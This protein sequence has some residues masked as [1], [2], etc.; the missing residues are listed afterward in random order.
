MP[1]LL[2]DYAFDG[3]TLG[4]APDIDGL[5]GAFGKLC[6]GRGYESGFRSTPANAIKDTDMLGLSLV[7]IDTDPLRVWLQWNRGFNIFDAPMM[8]NTYFGNT[9]PQDQSGRYRLVGRRRHEHASRKSAQGISICSRTGGLSVTHPNQNVSSQFGFQGLM[10]GGILPAGG[11]DQQDRHR[12]RAWVCAMTCR[13]RPSWASSSTTVPR[14]GSRSRRPPT[15]C[16]P[17]RSGVRGNVYE[18]YVIQELDEQFRSRRN[19]QGLLPPRLSVLRLPV[20][21]QQQLG[22]RAREDLGRQGAND[23]D[24]AAVQGLRPVCDVRG[25]VLKLQ[26]MTRSTL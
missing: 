5:P 14:T 4:Y 9:V 1:S 12:D 26:F 18:A 10:T 6:Y 25:E 21:R 19:Q 24:H 22:R 15:T 17:R 20:H 2:I 13:P 23:D 7:P 8:S 16:G 3:M 11:P